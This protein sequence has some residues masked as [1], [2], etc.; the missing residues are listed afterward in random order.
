MI[1]H[2]MWFVLLLV[3]PL[4]SQAQLG[5]A[6][7]A[8]SGTVPNKIYDALCGTKENEKGCKVEFK[9]GKLIVDASS[10]IIGKEALYLRTTQECRRYFFGIPDCFS[11]Q[12][13]TRSMLT[14]RRSDGSD[15][16]ATFSFFESEVVRR[17]QSRSDSFHA[18]KNRY[19]RTESSVI[20]T[21]NKRWHDRCS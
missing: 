21:S 5:N 14:Y 7:N 2:L 6:D 8:S 16:I 4:A 3:K 13:V 9:D 17:F 19:G 11:W 15:G 18:R 10:G 20:T 1:V 12:Y